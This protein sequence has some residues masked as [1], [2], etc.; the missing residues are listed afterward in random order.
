MKLLESTV[1]E[2]FGEYVRGQK[3]ILTS[4]EEYPGYYWVIHPITKKPT[5][6]AVDM[7]LLIELEEIN[8]AA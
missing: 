1:R 6:N 5:T 4:A 7:S 2:D 8:Q 3:I